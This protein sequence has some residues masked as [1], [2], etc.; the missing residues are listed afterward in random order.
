[1]PFKQSQ[2]D[3]LERTSHI[4]SAFSLAGAGFIILTFC[5][6]KRFHR[7]IN[8]LAF[9]ASFGNIITNVATIYSR[10]GIRAGR[11]SRLCQAQAAIIQWAIPADA[12]FVRFWF[13]VPSQK[14]EDSFHLRSSN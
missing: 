6:S 13:L 5:T 9:F 8:R 11:D 12:L 3:T 7:P 10:A 14:G 1:M 4:S 2:L